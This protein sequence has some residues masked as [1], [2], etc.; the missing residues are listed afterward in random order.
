MT[1]ISRNPKAPHLDVAVV[2]LSFPCSAEYV[3]IARLAILGIA[4]R[5]QFSYDE[6]EDVRLAVGEACTHAVERSVRAPGS[7]PTNKGYGTI[8][9]ESRVSASDLAIDVMDDVPV[10]TAV[11]SDPADEGEDFEIDR[12][13]LGALLMEILVDEVEVTSGATGTCVHLLK[14]A[15]EL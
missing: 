1:E 9:I 7:A 15:P 13:G 14:R 12:P 3:S 5:M 11:E 8:T 6:V 2:K 4:S 10:G